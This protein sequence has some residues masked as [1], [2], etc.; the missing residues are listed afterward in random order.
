MCLDVYA[1]GIPTS[2]IYEKEF[3]EFLK[4]DEVLCTY[5]FLL[6]NCSNTPINSL[7]AIYPA[8]LYHFASP[9]YVEL[10]G[11]E[12]V[13]EKLPHYLRQ[14]KTA[15][16]NTQLSL[17]QPDPNR[18]QFNRDSVVGEWNPG[19]SS[20]EFV[21]WPSSEDV[22]EDHVLAIKNTDFSCWTAKLA[23]PLIAGQS[24]WFGWQAVVKNAGIQ[25]PI[26]P[27]RLPVVRL[28][29]ASPIDVHRTLREALES[30]MWAAEVS[31]NMAE[32][33]HVYRQVIRDL[34]LDLE[35]RVDLQYFELEVRPGRYDTRM[36]LTWQM[37]R[38]LRMLA[39]SPIVPGAAASKPYHPQDVDDGPIYRWKSGSMLEPEHVWTDKGFVLHLQLLFNPE[40]E[41]GY[42]KQLIHEQIAK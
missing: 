12:D 30:S 33:A 26:T 35:R 11:V 13:S 25:I 5:F 39:G 10:T 27:L 22:T 9:D 21:I 16:Q 7:Y 14:V 15:K 3:V 20:D 28:Q 34:G 40:L 32:L 24:R 31:G 4:P 1:K 42:Q 8:P 23:K 6:K 29:I 2:I 18:P 37:E 36:M 38:D 41:A 17:L 19:K